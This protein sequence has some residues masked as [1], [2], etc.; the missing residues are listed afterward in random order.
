MKYTLQ[1]GITLIELMVTV[2]IIGI[3]AA[4]AIPSYSEYVHRGNRTEAKAIL[5]EN[6]QF[7]ERNFT[8]S[9]KYNKD[10]AGNDIALPFTASPKTGTAL[11]NIS[12]TLAATTYTITA[13][14][15]SGRSMSGD[16]CGSLSIDQLGQK[17]VAS[18]S[19]DANSCWKK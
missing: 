7:L 19:L 8:E 10:S 4:I 2:G 17:T 3:L 6:A 12:A 11:Y 13:T 16:K 14:P 1:H 5:L 15:V 9:N 18:A